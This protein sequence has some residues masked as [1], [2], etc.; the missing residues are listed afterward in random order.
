MGYKLKKHI[1]YW[2]L[3]SLVVTIC[4]VIYFSN[5]LGLSFIIAPEINREY[6]VIENIQLLIILSMIVMSYRSY[7]IAKINLIKYVF[8]GFVLFSIFM[9]LEEIDYG[10]HLFDYFSGRSEQ[11]ALA[12][13]GSNKIR[14]I[15]NQ[16]NLVHYMKNFVYI[17]FILFLVVVPA[18][19]R[20]VKFSNQY[21]D[22]IIPSKYFIYTLISMAL[23]NQLAFF[24]DKA[25]EHHNINSLYNNISEFEEVFI[26]YIMLL[27]LLELIHRKS[28]D[29][30][31]KIKTAITN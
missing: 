2:I 7:R 16:W 15:H 30:K 10:A 9:F 24:L 21:L 19:L 25:I 11:E 3:P 22:W 5:F 26:Y 20:K 14:N 4:M 31:K 27:Y 1:V 29:V 28:P 12:E 6:G 13:S 17:S 8:I 18:I 23:V